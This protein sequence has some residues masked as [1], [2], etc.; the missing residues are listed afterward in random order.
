[1][2]VGASLLFWARGETDMARAFVIPML[3]AGAL[4]LFLGGGLFQGTWTRQ[5]ASEIIRGLLSEIRLLPNEGVY[6]IELVGELAGL[7]A[8][9]QKET[10]SEACASG[11]SVSLVAG[12]GFVQD[13]TF[14]L[15]RHV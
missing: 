7:L 9:G 2:F 15:K 14:V 11:R 10:A 5:E 12:A 6:E 4:I 13:P 3:V 1:M 8:L